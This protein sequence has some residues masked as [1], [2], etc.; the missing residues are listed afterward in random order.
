MT[1]IANRSTGEQRWESKQRSWAGCCGESISRV[2]TRYAEISNVRRVG[3]EGSAAEG[4]VGAVLA[5]LPGTDAGL[6]DLVGVWGRIHEV[7][8]P[9]VPNTH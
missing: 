5:E 7:G 3:L 9:G 6:H 4:R 8:D 1:A 2:T